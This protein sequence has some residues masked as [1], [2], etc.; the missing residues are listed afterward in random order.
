MELKNCYMF[1][2][3]I[4]N[5]FTILFRSFRNWSVALNGENART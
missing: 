5:Y 1:A 4:A 2:N 3:K